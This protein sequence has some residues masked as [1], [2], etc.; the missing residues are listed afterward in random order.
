M[1]VRR[2]EILSY[3]NPTPGRSTFF[4]WVNRGLVIP[5]NVKGYYK[6]NAT[7]KNLNLPQVD[8]VQRQKAM[9]ASQ[10]L[11]DRERALLFTAL[12]TLVEETLF[13]PADT[14]INALRPAE[15][16][17]V[18]D[19]VSQHTIAIEELNRSNMSDAEAGLARLAYVG[20]VL[21]AYDMQK[22]GTIRGVQD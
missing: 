7:L 1:F 6:L 2:E 22:T 8:V 14:L 16:N 21:D 3:F 5:A 11:V 15:M 20:G 13:C 19:H 10:R 9:D 17:I 4:D 18:I 12:S